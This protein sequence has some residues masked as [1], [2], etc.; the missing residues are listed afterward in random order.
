MHEQGSLEW[1]LER[2][3]KVTGS[4]VDE[5]RYTKG[6]TQTA[7]SYM[8]EL[9]AETLTGIP[10][11]EIRSHIL[12]WGK[13]H[14]PSARS[15]YNFIAG[16]HV[17]Q[18]G[19]VKHPTIYK[20]GSSPDALVGDDGVLEIKCPY[21]TKV[22]LRTFYT[23]TV[24]KEYYWQVVAHLSV[25]GRDWCDFVS[26]DPRCPPECDTAIIRVERDEVEIEDLEDSVRRFVEQMEIRL[27]KIRG[28]MK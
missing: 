27:K 13:K 11:D 7:D 6:M 5:V 26:F 25:T 24:P 21:T 20:F 9:M 22:H 12:E 4:R 18:V 23:K 14:E 8:Y 3:G 19:F 1:K 15:Q 28:E 10:G 2:L 16:G 17:Q